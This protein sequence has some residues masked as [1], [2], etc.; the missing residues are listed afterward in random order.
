MAPNH[1]ALTWAEGV[2]RWV[3]EDYPEAQR[4]TLVM[5]NLNTH[6][7]VSLYK[8]FEPAREHARCWD[9]LEFVYTP[10]HGSWL[11]IAECEFSV[12]SRQCLDRRIADIDTLRNEISAWTEERN[13][14][15]KPVDLRC[16]TA[17][18]RIK[19]RH[20]YPKVRD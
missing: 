14:T 18:A 20:L 17:D 3:E 15:S 5:D 16:T 8:T 13:R 12:L 10:K 9:K 7:G 6:T 4:I 1:T 19:L 11:N 2:R